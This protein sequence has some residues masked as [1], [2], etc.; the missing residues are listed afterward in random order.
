MKYT[1]PSIEVVNF[2]SS[3]APRI[4]MQWWYATAFDPR[5]YAALPTGHAYNGP[6]DIR[7][8]FVGDTTNDGVPCSNVTIY[9][10]FQ[11]YNYLPADVYYAPADEQSY[12]LDDGQ[13]C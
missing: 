9:K 7:S 6:T 10:C 13:S 4:G 2:N 5:V 8:Q 3:D 12:V 11:E 1:T